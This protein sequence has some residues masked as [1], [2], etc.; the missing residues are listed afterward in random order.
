M[1]EISRIFNERFSHWHIA[2]PPG[3]LETRQRGRLQA[4][5]W[6]IQ[7]LFGQDDKGSYLDYYATHRMTNDTHVRIYEHG[8]VETLEAPLEFMVFPKDS[9]KEEQDQ[10]KNRYF[11]ENRRIYA[12]LAKKGFQ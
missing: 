11:E 1:S 5:G 12:E 6:T 3:A 4:A 8:E 2:L 9:T 7:Y 10:I